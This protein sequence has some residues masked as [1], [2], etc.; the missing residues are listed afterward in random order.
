MTPDR[1]LLALIRARRNGSVDCSGS[2][3]EAETW[4]PTL[5]CG[6]EDLSHDGL[7]GSCSLPSWFFRHW[8]SRYKPRPEAVGIVRARTSLASGGRIF[9]RRAAHRH[10]KTNPRPS[11]GA[12]LSRRCAA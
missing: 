7:P 6:L 3:D 8:C 4:R 2:K 12:A 1:P 9:R 11:A 5:C 10:T